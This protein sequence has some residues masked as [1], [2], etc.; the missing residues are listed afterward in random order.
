MSPPAEKFPPAPRTT[1]ICTSGS[2]SNVRTSSASRRTVLQSSGLRCCG[3]S[4]VTVA[5]APATFVST[6]GSSVI[7]AATVAGDCPTMGLYARVCARVK[8]MSAAAVDRAVDVEA[9]VRPAALEVGHVTR[10]PRADA[11]DVALAHQRE[12]ATVRI[13]NAL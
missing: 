1:T 4:R 7:V 3:R 11:F 9:R 13:Q 8:S 10:H 2:A 12:D 5:T 6:R